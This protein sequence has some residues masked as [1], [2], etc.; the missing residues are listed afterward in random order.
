MLVL[1]TGA[2]AGF[3]AEIARRYVAEGHRV[4]L[5]GRRSD[6]LHALAGS[7]AP[8]AQVAAFDLV[9]DNP[10]FSIPGTFNTTQQGSV[11]SRGVEAQF[12]GN[13]FDGLNRLGTTI[14]VVTHDPDVAKA[15]PRTVTIRDG[16]VGGEGRS[17][18]EY[19]VVAADGSLP[20][21][22]LSLPPSLPLL[23]LKSKAVESLAVRPHGTLL[24]RVRATA[25]GG[26][27]T[28]II[29][30]LSTP[31]S[32]AAQIKRVNTAVNSFVL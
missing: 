12:V 28:L 27:Q 21:P 5:T 24:T 25:V 29:L 9:R 16:R 10:P 26:A 14:V 2:S 20:L 17:G 3:G 1:I 4:I 32:M 15:F 13:L 19:S 18:E 30:W 8:Q 11:R 31:T 6:R 22:P 7:L 23:P